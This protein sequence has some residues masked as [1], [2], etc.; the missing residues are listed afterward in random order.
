VFI[1]ISNL[2]RGIAR[3][4]FV[5]LDHLQLPGPNS[6]HALWADEQDK[7]WHKLPG[8]SFAI[9]GQDWL[10]L[11]PNGRIR[12]VRF[13]LQLAP[14]FERPLLL[15]LTVG[16]EGAVPRSL[17]VRTSP[18]VIQHEWGAVQTKGINA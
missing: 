16:A 7:H 1:N 2:G 6:E 11:P 9:V 3:D 13:S 17:D 8:S 4:L 15:G 14:P 10:K 12:S 18:E 5:T